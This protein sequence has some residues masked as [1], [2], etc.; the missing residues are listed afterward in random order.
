MLPDRLG[1]YR[2]LGPIG[3]GGMG[4]VYEAEDTRLSRRVALKVLPEGAAAQPE[5]RERF[6][7]EARAAAALNHPNIVTLYSIEEIGGVRFLTMERIEGETLEAQIAGAGRPLSEILAVA[8]PVADA[9]RAAHEKGIAHRDLKPSNIMVGKDGRVRVLDF[10]LARLSTSASSDDASRAP[11][12]SPL[13]GEGTIVG[14][15]PYMSPEQLRGEPADPR[16]DIFA[17]GV[18]VYELATGTHPF[19]ARTAAE[20]VSAILRDEPAP[21]SAKNAAMPASLDALLARCLAKRP[22]ERFA[23]AGELLEELRRLRAHRDTPAD[24]PSIAVLPF[25]DMSPGHD[26]DYLCEGIAEEIINA[27]TRVEGLRVLSRMSSFQ[28]KVSGGDS[29][30]IGRRLGVRHLLEGS[31]RKAADR[32]RIT[33]QLIETA[34]GYHVWSERFD[35][36]LEDI[37]AIQ[38]EIAEA[39][40]SALRLQLSRRRGAGAAPTPKV[41][42]YEAYLR[43]WQYFHRHGKNDFHLARQLFRRATEIDP[44]FARAWAGIAEVS[45]FLVQWYGADPADLEEMDAASR[46]AVELEPESAEAHA[47]RAM[48]ASLRSRPEEARAEFEKAVAADP[49]RYETLYEF[50]RFC[51]VTGLLEEAVTH[52]ERAANVRPEEYQAKLLLPQVYDDLNRR[53]QSLSAARRGLEAANRHLELNPDDVRALYLGAGALRRLDRTE[54]ARRWLARAEELMPLDSIVQY[55]VAC[56]Y[57]STGEVDRALAALERALSQNFGHRSWIE[58][59]S[60]LA[61]LRGDPRFQALLDRMPRVKPA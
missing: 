5:R 46:R 12:V 9:L 10:G 2:I 4:E 18:V 43:A 23:S 45:A 55:N 34:G 42:A 57:A 28:F 44:R 19:P 40:A 8:E 41:E 52:F 21:A 38:D 51:V 13:T 36:K 61:S 50:G 26:Q 33:A 6:E 39:A 58:Q 53:E 48:V 54:E 31:V 49:G 29:R 1:P 20:L 17:F 14:T 22:E 37:F 59:D 15:V 60:D 27:L 47:A 56:F 30:E 32:L 35:R 24:L 3:R 11:T 7:R 16:S 25:A